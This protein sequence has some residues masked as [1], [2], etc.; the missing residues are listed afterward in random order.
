MDASAKARRRSTSRVSH[1]FVI[2]VKF[3][4]PECDFV[5][6]S[7][8]AA[9]G[10]RTGAPHISTGL[11]WITA[12]GRVGDDATGTGSHYPAA[13]AAETDRRAGQGRRGRSLDQGRCRR[14]TGR[15]LP[16]GADGAD[17]EHDAGGSPSPHHRA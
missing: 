7:A 17:S 15:P 5:S 16:A 13:G 11:R 1:V 8:T 9:T 12:N 14:A 2:R 3:T 4:A 10:K 6:L